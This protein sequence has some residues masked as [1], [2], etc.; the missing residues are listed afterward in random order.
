M[1]KALLFFAK[2]LRL[3]NPWK[4]KAP[5]L[6]AVPYLVFLMSGDTGHQAFLAVLASVTI[7]VGVAG[8]G[9]L[10]NDL[11]DREKDAAIQKENATTGLAWSNIVLLFLLFLA[12]AIAPWLY[13]PFTLQSLYLLLLQF[14]LFY[15]YAF[16]PLR[17]K[18]R[19]FL[20][21]I[22]DAS[23]AHLVPAL[24]AAYT[25]YTFTGRHMSQ[26]V[27]LLSVLCSWQ[28]LLGIRNICFHQL[29]DYENDITSGTRT[30]VTSY[31]LQKTTALITR[32]ILPLE[33]LGF[34]A[35]VALVSFAF[36]LLAALITAY[37]L[38]KFFSER[39]AIPQFNY[40][41]Y[42]YKFLD[43]LYIQWLPLAILLLLCFRSLQFLPV[44]ML[45]S[46]LFRSELKTVFI[47][48]FK[49]MFL[50]SSR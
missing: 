40:R 8:L 22:A 43:D 2:K 36:P 50:Q 28:V 18:E 29:K 16:K 15:A 27:L 42:A 24:L 34:L 4:F 19:N 35:F 39:K 6:M 37:W 9:Y 17:L 11:G 7:I 45:H 14:F 1:N 5:V 47:T 30:F 10:S 25:F 48:R 26:D 38:Y 12:L 41:D 46:L 31:G 20:G 3:S 32:I 23:Y 13:L 44:L 49:L 21:V 33:L